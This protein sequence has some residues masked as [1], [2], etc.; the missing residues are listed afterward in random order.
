MALTFSIIIPAYN[1]ER[2]LGQCLDSVISQIFS[3]NDYEII[4]V[5]DCSP[6]NQKLVIEKY[7]CEHKNIKFITHDVNK[8][9]G[10]ARNT[11]LRE[12]KGEWVLFVDADD[13]WVRTDVFE[14]FNK[15]VE[16]YPDVDIIESINYQ[17][18]NSRDVNTDGLKIELRPKF[19]NCEDY[20][21]Q[22]PHTCIWA[23]VYRK[24]HIEKIAFRE[25]VFYEDSDWKIKAFIS[26]KNI[27]L[28]NFP[29]YGYYSN[30]DSTTSTRNPQTYKYAVIA[31]SLSLDIWKGLKLSNVLK[32]KIHERQ[33]KI[34]IRTI[35]A[36]R[37]YHIKDGAE[38]LKFLSIHNFHKRL[39][40]LPNLPLTAFSYAVNH[41]QK[42]SSYI[43]CGFTQIKRAIHAIKKIQIR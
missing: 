5:N 27:L 43:I 12:A 29:F 8:K 14:T 37:D 6:D 33:V 39:S 38:L 1:A 42:L 19:V 16:I 22:E 4:V 21:L 31:D 25:N 17:N 2:Y 20:Y 40:P 35:L 18:V 26:A 15:L 13:Y 10:G 30:P 9:Q 11:G 23:A 32:D 7:Q 28:V 24:K 41:F 36:I 3:E 34:Y